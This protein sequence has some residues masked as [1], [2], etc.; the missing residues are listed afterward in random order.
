MRY[1][2]IVVQKTA[3]TLLATFI[4]GAVLTSCEANDTATSTPSSTPTAPSNWTWSDLGS[5]RFTIALPLGWTT[6]PQ[7]GI[8]SFVGEI[9]GDGVV[10]NWDLGWYSSDL[11]FDGDP[12]YVISVEEISEREAKL[13]RSTA[14]GAAGVFFPFYEGGDPDG[15]SPTRLTIYGEDLSPQQTETVFEMFRTIK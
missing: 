9:R 14:K 6:N 4:I 11:P 3:M 7:Q 12:A 2:R 13:V 5:D 1:A 10:L 15:P 8:D